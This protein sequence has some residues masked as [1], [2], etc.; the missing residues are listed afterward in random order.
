MR[1]DLRDL[2][3]ETKGF[4]HPGEGDAL[5]KWALQSQGPLVEIG[6]YCGKSTL[7]I[8]SA[9]VQ[10]GQPVISIDWHRGNPEMR[11]GNDCHDP[12]VWDA[13]IGATDTIP[14]LRR[15][16]WLA[17]LERTVSMI[18]A[19]SNQTAEWWHTPIGFLFIDAD[20]GTQAIDDYLNWKRHLTDLLLFHDADGPIASIMEACDLAETDGWELAE[21]VMSLRVYRR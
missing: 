4:L 21:Q 1:P 13:D 15:T 10:I 8:A 7:W 17:G 18:C 2:E 11:P 12:E 14:H 9:A 6:S 3:A 19:T 20:H 16:M 5:H